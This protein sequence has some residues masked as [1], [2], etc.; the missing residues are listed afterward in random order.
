MPPRYETGTARQTADPPAWALQGSGE[1]GRADSIQL[2]PQRRLRASVPI[3]GSSSRPPITRLSPK[4]S[5]Q[6]S[7]RTD[8]IRAVWR[9]GGGLT[10]RPRDTASRSGAGTADPGFQRLAVRAGWTG[11]QAPGE[12]VVRSVSLSTFGG[13]QSRQIGK[14]LRIEW[15][16]DNLGNAQVNLD[17]AGLEAL[18]APESA[19]AALSGAAAA[20]LAAAAWRRSRKRDRGRQGASARRRQ[21]GAERRR[22]APSGSAE[23]TM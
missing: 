17:E 2:L 3:R 5:P 20:V 8:G 21:P 12:W 23:V 4:R 19:G 11:N 14:P 1:F 15:F 10:R 22:F 18:D 13:N 6:P 9:S 16:G 7:R